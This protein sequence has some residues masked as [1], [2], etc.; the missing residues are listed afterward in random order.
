[1]TRETRSTEGERAVAS[2]MVGR[3]LDNYMQNNKNGPLPYTTHTQKI[4][5][6]WI[7][8]LKV[9]PETVKLL[10]ENTGEKAL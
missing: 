2:K 6:R 8:Y 7:K 1:M 3:K 4:N 10:E 5:L 9:R